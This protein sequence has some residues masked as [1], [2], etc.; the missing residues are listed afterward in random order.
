I[1]EIRIDQRLFASEIRVFRWIDVFVF[2]RFGVSV[3]EDNDSAL[4]MAVMIDAF[5][6]ARAARTLVH[7]RGGPPEAAAT[8]QVRLGSRVT[9]QQIIRRAANGGSIDPGFG[10]EVHP[11][12]RQVI[13]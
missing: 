2:A 10:C 6:A 3:V 7:R 9:D 11:C 5:I 1:P 13:S 4:N 8:R 12:Y